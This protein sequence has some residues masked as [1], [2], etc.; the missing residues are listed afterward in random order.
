LH[1]V[2][3][4][5]EKDKY[6]SDSIP[7]VTVHHCATESEHISRGVYKSILD[8]FNMAVWIE[9]TLIGKSEANNIWEIQSWRGQSNKKMDPKGITR[10][11]MAPFVWHRI[12]A[13]GGF[14]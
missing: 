5:F 8:P 4:L 1:L 3:D 14:L 6:S 13:I 12:R 11:D 9:E 2:G 7:T 10:D